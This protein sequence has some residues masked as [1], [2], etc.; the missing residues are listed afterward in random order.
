M[1]GFKFIPL[2]AKL[3]EPFILVGRFFFVAIFKQIVSKN[4]RSKLPADGIRPFGLRD[5][6]RPF[7]S[8]HKTLP[9]H[10]VVALVI[11]PANRSCT[12]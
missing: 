12:S 4:I 2:Q 10:L 1:T 9:R 5:L 8:V 11:D 7:S 6:V 3:S